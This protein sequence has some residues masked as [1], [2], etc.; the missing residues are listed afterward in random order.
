MVQDA[1][2]VAW[3]TWLEELA[4]ARQHRHT[5]DFSMEEMGVKP[6]D[7]GITPIPPIEYEINYAERALLNAWCEL[8]ECPAGCRNHLLN[9]LAFKMGRLIV[10][11]WIERGGSRSICCGPAR[12][13]GCWVRTARSS[14]GTHCD[15]GSRRECGCLIT[16]YGGEWGADGGNGRNA[17]A[18]GR[19][20]CE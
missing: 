14:A 12:P 13:M 18:R 9:V 17:K 20:S 16:I 1:P 19:G 10:K 3:P 4:R 5:T 15:L 7:V 6:D 2:I 11:G 8:H